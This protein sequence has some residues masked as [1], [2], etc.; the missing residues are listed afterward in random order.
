MAPMPARIYGK[1]TEAKV[2]GAGL[3]EAHLH[4]TSVSPEIKGIIQGIIG[5][6][7]SDG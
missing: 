7:T 1:V 5:I 2:A 6:E 4:L 3:H